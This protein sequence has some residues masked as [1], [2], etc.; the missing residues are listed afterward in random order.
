VDE[1]PDGVQRVST[2]IVDFDADE[3]LAKFVRY[4]LSPNQPQPGV[5]RLAYSM[6]TIQPEACKQVRFDAFE[7]RLLEVLPKAEEGHARPKRT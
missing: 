1:L 6:V 7:S 4:D 5:L 3:V 2:Q